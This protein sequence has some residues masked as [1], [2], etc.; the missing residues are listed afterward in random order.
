MNSCQI[1]D[2]EWLQLRHLISDIQFGSVTFVIQDGHIIQVERSE[3]I[4]LDKKEK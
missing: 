2:E 1:S 3:K 4:R